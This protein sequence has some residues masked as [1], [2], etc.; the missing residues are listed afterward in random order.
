M[1]IQF[2][3][4]L[5]LGILSSRM[6]SLFFPVS[7]Y[8]VQLYQSH[9]A[10]LILGYYLTDYLFNIESRS[11]IRRISF[12]I[13]L[14]VVSDGFI[15]LI[16][17]QKNINYWDYTSVI[18][19]L[20]ALIL[21]IIIAYFSKNYTNAE[22]HEFPEFKHLAIFTFTTVLIISVYRLTNICMLAK[23]VPNEGRSL[24]MF[25]Y[26]IHHICHGLIITTFITILKWMDV[27]LNSWVRIFFYGLAG[28]GLGS[29]S[30]QIVYYAMN[31]LT[32]EAYFSNLSLYGAFGF[33]SMYFLHAIYLYN[34]TKCRR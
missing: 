4:L 3:F 16:L 34:S 14:G 12:P 32:D 11:K 33:T 10:N 2:S 13:V 17:T 29:I 15:Y 24:T 22:Q 27:K 26:E 31:P 5:L 18:G 6:I 23:D 30:D 21:L 20:A 25:G 9:I 1:Q 8:G 7:F 28:I 19:S